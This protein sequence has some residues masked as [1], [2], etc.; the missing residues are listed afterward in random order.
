MSMW[1]SHWEVFLRLLFIDFTFNFILKSGDKWWLTNNST[2]D[3]HWSEIE[4]SDDNGI[5]AQ[6]NYKTVFR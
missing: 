2:F 4:N 1:L 5:R 3:R 6:I